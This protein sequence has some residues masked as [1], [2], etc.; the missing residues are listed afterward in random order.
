MKAN[1]E[2]ANERTGGHEGLYANNRNDR[3][4][5][6]YAGVARKYWPYSAIWSIIDGIK[7]I[8]CQGID[9]GNYKNWKFVNVHAKG[10]AKLKELV[11]EFYRKNFWD[12]A[13]LGLFESQALANNVYDFGVNG[14]VVRAA[15]FLQKAYNKLKKAGAVALKEDGQIGAKTV[16]AVED[17]GVRLVYDE[18]N[19]LRE[20]HY[21]SEAKKP[22]QAEFLNTWLSRIIP[23]KDAA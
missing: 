22:G 12:T 1:F 14:G 5:E 18:Y 2:R 15:M 21:R 13:R 7:Q 3:G 20:A 10:N 4:G 17:L 9:L 8:H 19:R 23:F 6:T 11:T 16:A